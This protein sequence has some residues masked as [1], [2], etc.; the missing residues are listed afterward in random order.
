MHSQL[1]APSSS[2]VAFMIEG[3]LRHETTM[4]VEKT[5]VDSHGQSEVGFAFCYLLGFSLLPRLKNLRKQRLY[6]VQKGDFERYANL[7]SVMGRSIDWVCI[8]QQYDEMVKFATALRLG[9][10]DAE[11]ILRR[12]TRANVQHPTYK[13]LGELG[14]A[15]KTA[16]LCDYLRLESLRREIHE[17]LN[18][19]ESVE[20]R[21]RFHLVRQGRGVCDESAR[22]RGGVDAV[23]ALVAGEFGVCEHADG[24]AGARGTRV[25]R[26]VDG[27]GSA[28]VDAASVGAC[29][30]VWHV[31]IGYD[32][33]VAPRAVSW[34][35]GKTACWAKARRYLSEKL[36]F[37]TF[38]PY[39]CVAAFVTGASMNDPRIAPP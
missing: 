17:G 34:D 22:G 24:A 20:R 21:E 28:G 8:E 14:K 5:Y 12:F 38:T 26:L 25:A 4:A 37:A 10:A 31:R 16:F 6:R 19:I 35:R 36:S 15:V 23:F 9:T 2:E 27:Y 18:V 3:V 29:Q 33:G 13:A 39:G 11:T 32:L 30:S 7:Q 1:K